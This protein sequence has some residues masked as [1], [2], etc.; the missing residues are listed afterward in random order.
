MNVLLLHGLWMRAFALRQLARRLQ[1][2]GFTVATFDY[3]SLVGGPEVALPALARR[4]ER[5]DAVIGH[6]L[7][8][9]MAVEV[10][11]RHPELPVKRAVCLGSPLLG[12]GAARA[13]HGHPVTGWYV[14]R[15][16]ALLCEGCRPWEGPQQIGMIAGTRPVGLGALVARF[17][18]PHDGTVAVSETRLPG[19]ADHHEVDVSHTGLVFSPRVAAL[20]VR[21]L[22]HG[23]FAA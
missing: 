17:Q 18:E 23:R 12:S 8:G 22:R 16:A 9:L 2:E 13:L 6:S 3:P 20:A 11:R 1:A 15:S 14:G 19:L 4:L 5:A 10:L 21:F 7:G